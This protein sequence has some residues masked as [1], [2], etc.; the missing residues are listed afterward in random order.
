MAAIGQVLSGP[1]VTMKIVALDSEALV[2][3]VAYDREARMPPQ[4]YH[5]TQ[6]EHFTVVEGRVHT[7]VEGVEQI[8]DEGDGFEF[9]IDAKEVGDA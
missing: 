6:A 7:V 5:P 9:G 2:L 8:Y 1:G 4:H 3:D